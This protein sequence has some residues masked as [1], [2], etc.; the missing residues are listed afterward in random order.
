MLI[1]LSL[2][3]RALYSKHP[4]G[5]CCMDKKGLGRLMKMV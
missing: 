5:F 4:L 3:V 1:Q 2:F